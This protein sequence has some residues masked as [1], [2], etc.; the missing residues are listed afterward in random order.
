M[1]FMCLNSPFPLK[2]RSIWVE[3]KVLKAGESVSIPLS[4]LREGQYQKNLCNL[5]LSWFILVSIPLS[6]L[7]EGQLENTELGLAASVLS[8]FPFPT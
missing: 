2:G 1:D 5:P 4:H 3:E 6:H 7:R 8:Q